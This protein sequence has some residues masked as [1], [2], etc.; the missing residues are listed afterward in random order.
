MPEFGASGQGFA[1]TDPE[2]DHMSEAYGTP[3]AVYF[4]LVLE[5]RVVGGCGIAPLVGG[6]DDVCE[7][8]KMYFLPEARGQGCGKLLLERCLTAAK[9]FGYRRCYIETL[10]GMDTAMRLYEMNGF[11]RLDGP[12]GATGHFGCDRWYIKDL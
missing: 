6:T 10:T 12:L 7:L 3:R 11:V 5:G 1:I 8:R 4:V 9:E 2:V